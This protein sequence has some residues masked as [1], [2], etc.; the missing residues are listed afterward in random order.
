M[1]QDSTG[2]KLH[3]LDEFRYSEDMVVKMQSCLGVWAGYRNHA[4]TVLES[5]SHLEVWADNRNPANTTAIG[6]HFRTITRS[7]G[8][9]NIDTAANVRSTHDTIHVAIDLEVRLNGLPHHQRRW[10]ETFNRELL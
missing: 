10:I 4:E 8:T 3:H 7:D 6:Q 2:F 1:G 9:I 5:E